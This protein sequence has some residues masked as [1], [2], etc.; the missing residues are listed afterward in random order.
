MIFRSALMATSLLVLSGCAAVQPERSFGRGLDDT[1]AS[2]SIKSAMLRAE[3]YVLQGIDVEVTEGIALL[4]GT[5]PRE[6][7]RLMAECL[8]WSALAVRAVQNEVSVS[9]SPEFQDRSRDAWISQRVSSRL[10]RDV[11]VRSVNY[12][13]ETHAGTVYLLGVARTRGELERA[14]AQAALVDGVVE[15]ITY[16]RV[17]GETRETIAR[18]E[19]QASACGG[20]AVPAMERGDE[21]LGAP[22]MAAPEEV[23]T[24]PVRPID[25]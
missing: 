16:V 3:G 22:D 7:D 14:A 21:L 19:R 18:G 11:S 2:L 25:S 24:A 1:S 13:V 12:N 20:D 10:L 9:A 17:V 15:V 6:D 23:R 8:A 4:T 5:A